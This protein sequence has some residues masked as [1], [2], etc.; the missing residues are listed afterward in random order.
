[1]HA[2]LP[3]S[4]CAAVLVVCL[5]AC[6]SSDDDRGPSI[7]HGDP[8]GRTVVAEAAGTGAE[9]SRTLVGS[10]PVAVVAAADDTSQA[11]GASA[12]VG[13]RVPMLT[14]VPGA[15]GEVADELHRLGVERVL[16]VGG[17]TVPDGIATV[18]APGDRAG[19]EKVTGITFHDETAHPADFLDDAT[20]HQVPEQ[21]AL[22]G[23][24]GAAPLPSPGT[25]GD[26]EPL[27]T[28]SASWS[29][30]DAPSVLVSD[31]TPLAAVA[32]AVATG[33]KV[34]HLRA[35][36]PR[37]DGGG[38]EAVSTDHPVV[39]LGPGWGSDEEFAA[40][41]DTARTQPQLP[42]GGQLVFPGRR[43]VA[44]YGS[45]ISPSLGIL[46]EQGPAESVAR[47]QKLVEDYRAYSPEPV[48][49]AFEII[50]TVASSDAGPDGNF[51]NEWGPEEYLPLVDAITAAGG[52]AVI[53]LQPGLA[54]M[55]DQARPFAELL[56]R[57]NVGLALD[58]EWKMKP[59]QKPAA[60]IGTADAEEINKV[61]TWLADLTRDSGGPQKL[62]I[63]HQFNLSMITNRD[64]IDLSR[65]EL[66][67]SLHADGHGTPD[68]K[69]GTWDR[70]RE[71]LDP[72][73]WPAWKNFYDEDTPTFTPQ[74]TMDVRPRPWFVS[75]Q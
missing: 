52:Y 53:D 23:V 14:A 65:P 75:Y 9:S 12:A 27:G 28:R 29:G 3:R 51:T 45:P 31:T 66:A 69:M 37:V 47:V 58:S 26:G 63:L 39:A 46:G 19:L 41:V 61:V 1:M 17:A 50:G 30:D 21:P 15:D 4:A 54:D 35:P 48:V 25:P 32:T 5:A 11:V 20:V 70:L 8:H 6:G 40:H 57:P 22:L 55:L 10:S 60:Q 24:A 72:R 64:R 56:K 2:L 59:G 73:I 36:D 34:S 74:Q 33:A 7:S 71:G 16:R 67:V 13:M 43:F 62:L 49:P 42:G 18:D 68:L 44:A 38:V